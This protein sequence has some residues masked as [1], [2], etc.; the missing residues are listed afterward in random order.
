MHIVWSVWCIFVPGEVVEEAPILIEVGDQPK[1]GDDSLVLVVCRN[2][3]KNILMPAIFETQSYIF[4]YCSS[5]RKNK[6]S[7]KFRDGPYLELHI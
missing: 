2:E 3:P 5:E 7:L 6:S 4:L 1:L